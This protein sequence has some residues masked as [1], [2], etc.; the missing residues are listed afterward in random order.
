[1]EAVTHTVNPGSEGAF[2]SVTDALNA[3]S[4]GDVVALKPG[5]YEELLKVFKEVTLVAVPDDSVTESEAVVTN[6]VVIG[7]NATLQRLQIRGRIDVRKGHAVIEDCD[8][9]HG[10]DGVRVGEGAKLSI[11]R[12]RIHHCESGG[13]GIYFS[14]GSSGEVEDCDIYECRVNGIHANNASVA[15]GNSR[16]RDTIFGVYYRGQSTGAVEKNSIEHVQ[17]FGIYVSEGSD[18]VV[19][20]NQVRECGIHCGF[21]SQGGKGIW[22]ENGFEG[23]MHVQGGCDAK[24]G[25]NQISGKLDVDSAPVVA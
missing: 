23:S 25:P 20:G 10:A 7:A 17:K 3:A 24:L 14:P 2:N 11:R 19:Q 1:M 6:G 21:V 22:T 9:H 16:V 4:V 8:I 18:P 15:V 12:S 13:D 5:L